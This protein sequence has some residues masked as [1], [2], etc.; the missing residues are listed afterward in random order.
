VQLGTVFL[1]CPEAEI[2]PVYRRVL[3]EP[4]AAR[5]RLTTLYTGRL[6]RA[7]VTRFLDEM[8]EHEGETLDFPLQRALTG[9]LAR[10]GVAQGSPEHHAMWAGQAAAARRHQ[11][12]AAEL[13]ATLARETAAA[14][15]AAAG[16]PDAARGG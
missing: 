10:A 11:L 12:P 5:T 13:V 7:I 6:A 16:G 4:R 9:P 3:A 14:F 2:D 1:S 15:A 8:A